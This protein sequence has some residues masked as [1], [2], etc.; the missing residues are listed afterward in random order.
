V[1]GVPDLFGLGGEFFIGVVGVVGLG[2]VIALAFVLYRKL[3]PQ[4]S[5]RN[6]ILD[7]PVL[8]H[9]MPVAPEPHSIHRSVPMD[10]VSVPLDHVQSAPAAQEDSLDVEYLAY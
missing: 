4:R 6:F 2:V 8:A 7:S 3:R 9:P 1:G 5:L 10:H